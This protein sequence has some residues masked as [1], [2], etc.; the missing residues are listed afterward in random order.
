MMFD[1]RLETRH[2]SKLGE[3]E[4]VHLL[5]VNLDYIM[6]VGRVPFKLMHLDEQ[7]LAVAKSSILEPW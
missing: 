1:L 3:K 5:L 2:G 4:V 7:T 6:V